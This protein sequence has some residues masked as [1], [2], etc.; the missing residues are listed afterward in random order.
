MNAVMQ[1]EFVI[2][3]PAQGDMHGETF[4]I[5]DTNLAT[6]TERATARVKW[7]AARLTVNLFGIAP[8]GMV[9]T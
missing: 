6:A 1:Y 5:R 9:R 8:T 7:L 2:V 4:I 3:D